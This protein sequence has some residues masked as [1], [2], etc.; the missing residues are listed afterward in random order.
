MDYKDYYK[1][2][3]V[4]RK[5]TDK[6]IKSAYRKL[7]RQYHPDVH[8]G[9]KKAETRFQEI[10]E[11]YEVLSD[12]ENRK[13]YDQLGAYWKQAQAGGGARRGSGPEINFEDL[14]AGFSRG[15]GGG[16]T[17][18]DRGGGF[19]SF[20]QQFFG[21][22]ARRG[23]AGPGAPPPREPAVPVGE[24]EVTLE[25]AFTGTTRSLELTQQNSCSTC[26]GIGVSGNSLCP[27]CRGSGRETVSRQLEVKIPAGVTQGSK[28]KAADVV[29]SVKIR[30]HPDYEIK[31]RD[32]IRKLPISLYQ[33]VLGSE[34]KF[35]TPI[36]KEV[37][38]KVPAETQ[39]GK[40]FR[41]TGQ[42][43]PGA[44]GKPAGDLYVKLEVTLPTG[45]SAR[46]REL[47]AELASL[48]KS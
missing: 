15:G 27:K 25:E 47:F 17:A 36:G 29:L 34:L 32:L 30:P 48:R 46:E 3:G 24:V 22:S 9:D 20:F 7:A 5:A 19:S 42:G 10:N 26:G 41:L 1:I 44:G 2:L 16:G 31:G 43:L 37:T 12:P 4:D 39:N 14:F 28:V 13:K 18:Q 40:Q 23:G 35:A 21:G 33:A 38:L 45:L 8:P 6:E 11:A